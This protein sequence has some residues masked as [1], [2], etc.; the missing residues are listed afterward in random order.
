MKRYVR[1][2]IQ[3]SLA[4]PPLTIVPPVEA[5]SSCT[6][7]QTPSWTTSLLGKKMITLKPGWV[8]SKK[9]AGRIKQFKHENLSRFVKAEQQVYAQLLIEGLKPTRQ[10]CW[11]LKI[12]DFW[13]ANSAIRVEVDGRTHDKIVD[14]VT[15]EWFFRKS[16]IITLRIPNYDDNSLSSA[17]HVIKKEKLTWKK[18]RLLCNKLALPTEDLLPSFLHCYLNSV[19]GYSYWNRRKESKTCAFRWA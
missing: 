18:R 4:N 1:P 8:K 19:H 10:A 15:D 2:L 12:M 7:G 16:G 14:Y 17:I 6:C 3:P 5:A 9:T 13:F 11:G